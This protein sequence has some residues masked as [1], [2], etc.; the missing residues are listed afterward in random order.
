MDK[1]DLFDFFDGFSLTL[2]KNLEEIEDI[3]KYI[4]DLVEENTTLRLENNKLRERLA[5]I[6]ETKPGKSLF[7]GREHLEGIYEDGF[8][9]CNDAYGQRRES[10]EDC[11]MCTELLFRE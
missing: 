3:K 10:E 8:H 9:I 6:Q 5:Q 7:Q 11:M 4:Q 2:A 1:K